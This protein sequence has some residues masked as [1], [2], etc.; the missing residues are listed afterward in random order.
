M[1]K[2]IDDGN[3]QLTSKIPDCVI[4][5]GN[6]ISERQRIF[7]EHRNIRSRSQI[8]SQMWKQKGKRK[9]MKMRKQKPYVDAKTDAN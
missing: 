1:L 6:G 7:I 2:G 8:R 3:Q 4:F 9:Q 5:F